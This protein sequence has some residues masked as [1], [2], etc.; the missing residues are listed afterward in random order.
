MGKYLNKTSS[1]TAMRPFARF[2]SG[3]VKCANPS[4]VT[5]HNPYED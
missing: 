1:I 5:L 4:G 2:I 3:F